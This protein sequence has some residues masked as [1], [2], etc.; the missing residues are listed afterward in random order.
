M[1][2]DISKLLPFHQLWTMKSCSCIVAAEL[3][4][5]RKLPLGWTQSLLWILIDAFACSAVGLLNVPPSLQ[6][7]LAAFAKN[8]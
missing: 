4:L 7:L 8:K 1:V 6:T 5:A 2:A 3:G